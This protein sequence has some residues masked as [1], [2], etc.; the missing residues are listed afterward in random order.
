M[1][2]LSFLSCVVCLFAVCSATAQGTFQNLDFESSL[3]PQTQPAGF[4]TVADAF[5]G[6]NAFIYTQQLAQVGFNS[7]SLGSTW[8]SLQGASSTFGFHSLEGDYSALLQAGVTATPDGGFIRTDASISQTGLV[9]S[10]SKSIQ[11]EVF[12]GSAPLVVSLGGQQLNWSVLSASGNVFVIA[13]DISTFAG[14]VA[15]LKFDALPTPPGIGTP[16]NWIIDSIQFSDFAIPEPSVVAIS[17]LGL[18]LG[19]WFLRGRRY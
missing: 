17:A 5:P 19:R 7:P 1:K 10:T 12:I 8:V 6:W 15:E 16:S 3:V 4:V 13:S 9:P 18:I 14:Q 11:F 2:T